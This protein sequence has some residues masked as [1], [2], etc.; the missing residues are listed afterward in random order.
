MD[1]DQLQS[2]PD[3][4][5]AVLQFGVID[6]SIMPCA[7]PINPEGVAVDPTV[8]SLCPPMFCSCFAGYS[9][10]GKKNSSAFTHTSLFGAQDAE[11]ALAPAQAINV[12]PQLISL[13]PQAVNV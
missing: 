13:S 5:V 4:H 8:M 2:V 11:W 9:H 10:F 12:G 7:H 3:G 6:L 1:G